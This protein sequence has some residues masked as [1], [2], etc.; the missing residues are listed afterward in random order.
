MSKEI[1]RLV[2]G[3]P[4]IGGRPLQLRKKGI[5]YLLID[6]SDSMN[7]FVGKEALAL[8]EAN[9][10]GKLMQSA[11]GGMVRQ[12]DSEQCKNIKTKLQVAVAGIQEFTTRV[13]GTKLVGIILFGSTAKLYHTAS[14]DA[15]Q[16]ATAVAAIKQHPLVGGSTNLADA[17]ALLLG[18]KFPAIE[19]VI[20]VTDGKPDNKATAL[21]NA[22]ILKGMGTDILVIGTEDADWDFIAKLRS[23]PD[24][25]VR[26]SD[27]GLESAITD[28]AKLLRA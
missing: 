3:K 12:F 27:E 16:L 21:V 8:K 14:Y 23:R 9:T 11:D 2:D 4:T 15:R 5:V 7:H 22:E 17:L 6:V 28:S 13:L 19:T 26:T 18:G 10:G 20:I 1:I 24:L 25:S